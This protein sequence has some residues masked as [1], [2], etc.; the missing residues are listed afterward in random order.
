[1]EEWWAGMSQ[2]EHV[3]W[4]IALVASIVFVVIFIGTIVGGA[5]ADMEGVDTDMDADGGIGFQFISIK[6]VTG[7][8]TIFAW[9][10]IGSIRNGN[11]ATFTILMSIAAGLVMMFIMAWLFS[12][13][14]KQAESGTL[15][16]KN[17]VGQIGEVYIT[18]GANRSS[19]GKIQIKVQGSLRELE[20]LSDEEED[21][22]QGNVVKVLEVIS[23]ELL[24]IEKL[25]K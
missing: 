6:N 21:L 25:K 22:K 2:F 20:A 18:I 19:I 1:M 12:F 11:T 9:T 16:I 24:L 3:Y 23:G 5:D 13:I 15:Q 14:A 10:G 4:I 8:F 17:A 7:F